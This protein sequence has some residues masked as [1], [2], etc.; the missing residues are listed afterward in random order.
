DA[1]EEDASEEADDASSGHSSENVSDKNADNDSADSAGTRD[2]EKEKDSRKNTERGEDKADG[3]VKNSELEDNTEED[4]QIHI[5]LTEKKFYDISEE[6]LEDLADILRER[7]VLQVVDGKD[8][9]ITSKTY[10]DV[11]KINKRDYGFSVIIRAE[12]GDS[13]DEEKVRIYL[14]R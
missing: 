14:T 9:D 5:R 12:Y 4:S 11:E 10:M 13:S 7:K 2:E 1:S 8:K 3:S 6:E